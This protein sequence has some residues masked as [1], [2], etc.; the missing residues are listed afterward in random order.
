MAKNLRAKI[1]ESDTLTIFDVN[2]SSAD[3]LVKEA[4]PANITIA[5]GPREVA[6]SAVC[7]PL[8]N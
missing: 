2:S 4:I 1:P 6:E 7:L 8:Y 3:K 5:K